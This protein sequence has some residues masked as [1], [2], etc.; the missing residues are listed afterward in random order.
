MKEWWREK[1]EKR[2]KNR[3][4]RKNSDRYTFGDFLL[5]VLDWVP[6]LILLPFRILFWLVRRIGRFILDIN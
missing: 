5:D 6:E 3:K 2:Q 1:K 4:N